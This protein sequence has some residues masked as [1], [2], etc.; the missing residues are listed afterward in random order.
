[1]PPP[2]FWRNSGYHLLSKDPSGR[3]AV[4]DD[5]LRAYWLRPESHPVEESCDA[6]RAL[7]A[8]LMDDPRR[9]VIEAELDAMR[10]PD[11]RDNYRV[12]LRFRER[13][14]AADCV[15][16]CYAGLFGA[17]ST[18]IIEASFTREPNSSSLVLIWIL[19]KDVPIKIASAK[20]IFIVTPAMSTRSCA[21]H[22]LFPN[23]RG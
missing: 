2:D 19:P 3:L 17:A 20:S 10:D 23:A 9:A 4:T 13:L 8:A 7:H 12:V 5:F 21:H 22:G 16:A 11:A 18:T 6:E 15:E 1:M 14:L